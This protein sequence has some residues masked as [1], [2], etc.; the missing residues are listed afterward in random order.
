MSPAFT[1][2]MQRHLDP[3]PGP[4]SAEAQ[5][6]KEE[7]NRPNPQRQAGKNKCLRAVGEE[8]GDGCPQ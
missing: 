6:G 2:M 8:R 3:P 5:L 7:R 1:V 4:C